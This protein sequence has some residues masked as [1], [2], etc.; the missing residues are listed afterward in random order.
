MVL[1]E[2]L[3]RATFANEFHPGQ[4]ESDEYFWS[5]FAGRRPSLRLERAFIAPR[6]L[7]SGSGQ[8]S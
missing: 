4:L 6:R 5:G 2:H 8:L 3:D 1:F 7:C